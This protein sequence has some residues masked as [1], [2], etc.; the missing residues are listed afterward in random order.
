MNRDLRART[1]EAERLREVAEE[2][3]RAKSTFLAVM[4]HELRTPLNAIAGYVQLLTMGIHGPVT[5]AQKTALGRIDRSQ[6]HL[7][8]LIND[9]LDLARIEA[10]RVDYAVEDVPVEE[11][12]A[13][14]APMVEPQF[15]DKGIAFQVDLP[16]GL[17]MRA[18]R[19]KVQ[20][21]LI[22]LLGNAVKFT[23]RGGQVRIHALRPEH[24][25]DRIVV[26][27]SDTGVGIPADEVEKVFQPFVQVDSTDRGASEGSGLGLAI[28]RDMARGMG[29]DLSATSEVG[30]GSTFDL[31][32][33]ATSR[34]PAPEQDLSGLPRHEDGTGA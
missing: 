7:L 11:V 22:N 3:N 26:S 34:A 6:S 27:V 24:A 14:V 2:A 29:G 16:P 19:E 23:P 8:R 25:P 4:S 12:V 21:I 17:V 10:G 32:L 5:E 13:G 18:D 28:S 31:S 9:V 33:P 20:Q 15:T 30:K 1:K